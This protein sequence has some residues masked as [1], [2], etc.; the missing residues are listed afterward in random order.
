MTRGADRIAAEARAAWADPVR[1]RR[2]LEGFA[3]TEL[4]G[5]E[6]IA[7]AA[8]RTGDVRLR[9]HL[10]RHADDE[11]R[12]GRRFLEMAA[13]V[14][15]PSGASATP[16]A[17]EA[18][19]LF[20]R[21]DDDDAPRGAHGFLAPQALDDRGEI[22]YVAF[23]HV[24][25]TRAAELFAALRRAL[26]DDPATAAA[27]DDALR[28]EAYH[29]AY[30]GRWLQEAR[31]AGRGREVSR[32]LAA[33]RGSR[34]FGAWKRAGVRAAAR[35]GRAVL[36]LLYFTVVAPFALAAKATRNAGRKVVDRRPPGVRLRSQY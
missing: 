7:R 22:D 12:H 9:A 19:P 32:A 20:E 16:D 15:A 34:L 14:P 28:D 13:A 4:D 5:G 33:A 36:Y 8:A 11:R 27:L 25:E 1:R 2:T 21:A 23:L 3:R 29:V 6:D 35:F 18:P 17:G 10:L 26:A 24:A 31:A 30:T